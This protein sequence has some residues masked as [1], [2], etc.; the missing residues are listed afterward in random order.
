MPA[1]GMNVPENLQLVS[2][3]A[4]SYSPPGLP[5]VSEPRQLSALGVFEM[6]PESPYFSLC[7]YHV[8]SS[9]RPPLVWFIKIVVKRASIHSA[10]GV[11]FIV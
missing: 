10:A 2:I 4:G 1:S 7:K 9:L 8:F 5:H 6:P 3:F 11:E